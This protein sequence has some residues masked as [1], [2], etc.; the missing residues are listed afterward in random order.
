MNAT[1]DCSVGNL[2][3]CISRASKHCKRNPLQ[4]SSEP[5]YGAGLVTGLAEDIREEV[6]IADVVMIDALNVNLNPSTNSK[7]DPVY[8]CVL[9]VWSGL[10]LR[11]DPDR[12]SMNVK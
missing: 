3:G 7:R 4:F 8:S 5:E 10:L 6:V 1:L 2:C 11:N 12:Q 9:L